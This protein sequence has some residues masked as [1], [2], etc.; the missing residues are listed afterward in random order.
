[1]PQTSWENAVI[2]LVY[3]LVALVVAVLIAG[4]VL[5]VRKARGHKPEDL[6]TPPHRGPTARSGPD[7]RSG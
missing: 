1:M 7:D 2:T 3:V 6:D 4:V 5:L